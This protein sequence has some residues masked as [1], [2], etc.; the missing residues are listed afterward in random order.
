VIYRLHHPFRHS[1]RLVSFRSSTT[2]QP[3]PFRE[4]SP[5]TYHSNPERRER[6]NIMASTAKY[7]PAPQQEPDDDYTQ[8]PPAYG[9]AEAAESSSRNDP[10]LFA[11]PRSSDDNIPDDFKVS[12]E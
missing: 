2:K 10:S 1:D 6:E 4:K 11:Q 12:R 9:T 7:Q 3:F 5:T 8:A